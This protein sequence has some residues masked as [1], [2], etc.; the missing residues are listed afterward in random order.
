MRVTPCRAAPSA[1]HVRQLYVLC[2]FV[3]D[4][5]KQYY[6]M[7]CAIRSR[8][9][10]KSY[11]LNVI[12]ANK[13]CGSV[14]NL[15]HIHSKYKHTSYGLRSA[16][17]E[18]IEMQTVDTRMWRAAGGR[19]SRRTCRYG[20]RTLKAVTM[21]LV[22]ASGAGRPRSHTHTHLSPHSKAHSSVGRS[23]STLSNDYIHVVHSLKK[24]LNV[25]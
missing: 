5:N 8:N 11:K 16:A 24:L 18:H 21:A 20:L 2:A 13:Q 10:L 15:H 7:A 4:P 22:T 12:R 25:T 17:E 14:Q 19:R 23:Y 9:C 6:I 3:S 1:P